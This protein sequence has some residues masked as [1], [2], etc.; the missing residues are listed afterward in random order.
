MTYALDVNVQALAE[1]MGRRV[2]ETED[3]AQAADQ[4]AD[5]AVRRAQDA[6]AAVVADAGRSEEALS[7]A[8]EAELTAQAAVESVA[9]AEAAAGE[10]LTTAQDAAGFS[11]R[12]A[13]AAAEVSA[14]VVALN[15]GSLRYV[16]DPDGTALETADGAKWSPAEEVTPQHFGAMADGVSDD[17]AAAQA[18]LNWGQ[19][20]L[21]VVDFGDRAYRIT[22]TLTINEP[23]TVMKGASGAQAFRVT[24]GMAASR[25]IFAGPV[26]DPALRI[27]GKEPVGSHFALACEV[28]NI[29]FFGGH[30]EIGEYA[31]NTIIDGVSVRRASKGFLALGR[32]TWSLELNRCSTYEITGIPYDLQGNNHTTMYRC[33]ANNSN[34]PNSR[35][36][37]S[38]APACVRIGSNPL[39]VSGGT[40]TVQTVSIRDC[41][42]ESAYCESVIWVVRGFSVLIEG[43]YIEARGD[44]EETLSFAAWPDQVFRI[45][46][47]T[48]DPATEANM[49]TNITISN[50]FLQCN[51]GNDATP[52]Q[53]QSTDCVKV[54]RCNSLVVEN[55]HIRRAQ[56][57]C[58]I[59]AAAGPILWS[60]N[61]VVQPA[62][63][64]GPV[65]F[66]GST[67]N[68]TVVDY[69]GK[70]ADGGDV[71]AVA[72]FTPQ[73]QHF[74]RTGQMLGKFAD[75]A[76]PQRVFRV[77][78]RST[79]PTVRAS[80]LAGDIAAEDR[81]YVDNGADFV[82]IIRQSY[83][84]QSTPNG[85]NIPSAWQLFLR[86]SAGAM[87][88]RLVL[89]SGGALYPGVNNGQSL[90]RSSERWTATYS[91][92]FRPGSGAPIWTS[93]TG[94]P[95]GSVAAAAGS[96]YT[97]ED[98]GPGATLY[99]KETGSGNTGWV[100]K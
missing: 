39:Q 45:G 55:N 84:V 81:I 74:G 26:G 92:S 72:G 16:R 38:R 98:G 85:N 35:K 51:S 63:V 17:T 49:P 27:V 60:R 90:G 32:Q 91:T 20:K 93:G 37:T 79:N 6:E 64:V 42:F 89:N 12:A 78:S 24:E 29:E 100:A 22:S 70:V 57:E 30:V 50:N 46:D 5:V 43:N 48:L 77:R 56:N 96:I 76:N 94:S 19:T 58:V 28:R 33:T 67:A 52:G 41:D 3:R 71:L 54:E 87:T 44:Y 31:P 88:K 47:A 10:A 34:I 1:I 7:R 14:P 18:A 95:E 68:L 61:V 21:R 99:V 73:W 80:V 15:V 2:G 75:D 25:I 13:A 65:R 40:N 97:R 9:G 69:D 53:Y 8:R 83:E 4:K 82:D 62:D 86:T 23:G 36:P 66:S 11:S 59:G